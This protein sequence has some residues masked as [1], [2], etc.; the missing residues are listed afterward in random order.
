MDV[1]LVFIVCSCRIRRLRG[2]IRFYPTKPRTPTVFTILARPTRR[3]APRGLAGR[4]LCFLGALASL[5]QPRDTRAETSLTFKD[6]SWQEDNNRIRVD[7]QYALAET[8]LT[9]DARLKLM[10]LIDTIAGATPTGELPT[11]PGYQDAR[12]EDQRIAWDANLAYQFKRV[13]V[14]ASYGVSRESDYLSKGYSLN[15]LT[16]FNEKNTLLLLGWGHTDDTISES[17]LGWAHDRSKT[18]DDLILGLTQLI[19]PQMSV[20]ANVSYGR[21]TGFLSDPYKVVSTTMLDLDP[22]TYYT[23]PENRPREKDKVS[24]FLGANRHFDKLDGA[25]DASYR[26]YHDTFGINSHTVELK[27]IQRIGTHFTVEPLARYYRQSAADFYYYDLDKAGIVT[28]Y[29]PSLETG[30]GKAPYYSSDYRLSRLETVNLG[31]KLSWIINDHCSIDAA[32]ERYLMRGL[33]NVTPA[34]AYSDANVFTV[35]IKLSR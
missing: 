4:G 33:D 10:G 5:L 32:Y 29:D 27:W 8:D 22:G 19:S 2:V 13:N 14:A 15:T 21:S 1:H 16:D 24:V 26:F 34:R 9:P 17:K 23:P 25:L 30:T 7:S 3:P 28:S 6:Q 31:L 18:G 12:M 35:G 11:H 20:T